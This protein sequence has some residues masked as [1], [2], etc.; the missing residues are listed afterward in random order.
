MTVQDRELVLISETKELHE[1]YS[2]VGKDCD[3]TL[4]A[5]DFDF[6]RRRGKIASHGEKFWL[7]GI[8]VKRGD[9]RKKARKK[10][11]PEMF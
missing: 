8:Y 6:L 4:F 10:R 2:S 11:P 5:E 1:F 3:V 9:R 7:E